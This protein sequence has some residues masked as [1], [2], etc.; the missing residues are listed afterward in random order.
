MKSRF[1]K[2]ANR[3]NPEAGVWGDCYRAA[4]ASALGFSLEDVP[5]VF[6]GG[7]TGPEGNALMREWLLGQGFVPITVVY[8]ASLDELLATVADLN[9]DT[10]YVLT[11]RSKNGCN[12]CVVGLN[13]EIVH[14]PSLDNSGIV[15]PTDDGH[16]F[17]EYFGTAKACVPAKGGDA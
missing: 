3:H 15:G 9:P 14:D 12:H 4:V 8:Q 17:I 16:Y 13:D 10:F 11:G 1:L 5:H 6:D 7:R 2:Q